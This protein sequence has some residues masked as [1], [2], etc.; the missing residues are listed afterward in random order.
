[1]TDASPHQAGT[2]NRT[3][4]HVDKAPSVELRNIPIDQLHPHPDNPRLQLRED[5]IERLAAEMTAVGFGPQHAIHG[6]PIDGGVQIIS[7]H[8]RIEA[9]RRAGLAEIPA[10]VE[11][12]GD[13]EAFMQLVL[14]NTQGELSP[15]EIGMH[16][17]T[18][19]Q[20]TQGK[21]GGG[22]SAYAGKV[23]YGDDSVR[24]WRKAAEVYVSLPET[25][26][27]ARP[28]VRKKHQ[29]LYEIG[30][31]P[32]ASWPLLA[33]SLIQCEWSAADTAHYVK[34]VREFDIPEQWSWWLPLPKVVERFLATREFAPATVARLVSAAG[35]VAEW[36]DANVVDKE[37][38]RVDL[39]DWLAAQGEAGWQ[40]RAVAGYLQRLI[41]SQFVVEGWHH[42][43][44][45]DHI[46]K[47]DDGTVT[48]LLTDPPYGMNY[49][50]DYRLDRRVERKHDRIAS[51]DTDAPGEVLAMLEAFWDKLADNAHVLL[52]CGW[53]G[54][55]EMR[56]VV[57]KAGYTLR[58]SLV[59]DKQATGMGDPTTTFAPAH[60]RILHAVKGSPPLYQ[61]AADLLRHSRCDSSRHPTEKPVSLLGELIEATTVDGQVVADPYGGVAST[62]AAAKATGR[63]WFGCELDEAY[64]RAGEERLLP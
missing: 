13:D 34:S 44:W 5:V 56:E 30:K 32:S 15:L 12:M 29:H 28:E 45:R 64:W 6:R 49:Q 27:E 23:G 61:R 48:L 14:S 11:E 26:R 19:V 3:G 53:A 17:L 54:E 41:A 62:P 47:L 38:A 10:W 33:D 52:F 20:L 42:G 2:T 4:E 31:A 59:W 46:G 51:D 63:R 57:T 22:L 7:G 18:A 35:Q 39:H 24:Q 40:P 8:H 9:A 60:E 36:I 21:S 55:P 58:G 25:F 37:R 43:D 1:M 50:S 16:A